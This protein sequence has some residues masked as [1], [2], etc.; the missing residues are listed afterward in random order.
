M[1]QELAE[2]ARAKERMVKR[3]VDAKERRLEASYARERKKGAKP[4]KNPWNRVRRSYQNVI[5]DWEGG[6]LCAP[7]SRHP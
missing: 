3:L 7:S 2:E 5:D 4:L 6:I 1:A